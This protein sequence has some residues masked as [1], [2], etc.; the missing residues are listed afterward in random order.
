MSLEYMANSRDRHILTGSVI[1]HQG[2]NFIQGWDFTHVEN[3]SIGKVMA[4]MMN[5]VK[6]EQNEEL[7]ER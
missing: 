1:L 2:K 5:A 4:S 7:L 6:V 3:R